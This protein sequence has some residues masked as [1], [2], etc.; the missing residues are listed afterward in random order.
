MS[1]CWIDPAPNAG[2]LVSHSIRPC[3]TLATIAVFGTYEQV[4][5]R[6]ARWTELHQP[7]CP[8]AAQPKA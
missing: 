7:Q 1:G 3:F 5:Q 4:Q 6:I 8:Y 2:A